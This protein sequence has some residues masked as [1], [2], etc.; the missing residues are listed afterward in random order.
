MGS[1]VFL[2]PSFLGVFFWEADDPS[3]SST[4]A[5]S[6]FVPADEGAKKKNG[7][8]NVGWLRAKPDLKSAILCRTRLHRG[9]RL[10]K[11]SC[12]ARDRTNNRCL[13]IE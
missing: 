2:F 7:K 6:L 9:N 5:L 1:H 4:R 3:P 11:G 8:N 10:A 13:V 12:G